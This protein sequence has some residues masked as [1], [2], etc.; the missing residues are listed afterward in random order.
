MKSFQNLCL[1]LILLCFPPMAMAASMSLT[2]AK[3]AG[4]VGEKA[5]GLIAAVLPNPSPDIQDLVN[6]T[7]A[8]RMAV[9][10]EMA[11]AQNIPLSD[12]RSITAQKLLGLAE[13]GDYILTNGRWVQ[14]K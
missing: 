14:K 2:E 6:T 7:N 12:V 4:L 1:L 9:Y 3:H 10:K 5:D 13:T 11:A 8:G